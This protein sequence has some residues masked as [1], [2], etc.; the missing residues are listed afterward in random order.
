[1]KSRLPRETQLSSVTVF[2]EDY[3]S[4]R[5]GLLKIR[6]NGCVCQGRRNWV[7]GWRGRGKRWCS[8]RWRIVLLACT[9]EAVGEGTGAGEGYA[10]V[11][12]MSVHVLLQY[13]DKIPR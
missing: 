12:A 4:S 3:S 5:P 13:P 8:G 6:D 1:M 2:A 9:S 7:S 11:S 10:W